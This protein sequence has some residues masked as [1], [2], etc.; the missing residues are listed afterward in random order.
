MRHLGTGAPAHDA[1]RGVNGMSVHPGEFS[2]VTHSISQN[3]ASL[4]NY[5]ARRGRALGPGPA[6]AVHCPLWEFEL[7]ERNRR[8]AGNVAPPARGAAAVRRQR[9]GAR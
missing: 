8:G 6:A 3:W 4:A 1:E 9:Y 7:F 5:L 2:E